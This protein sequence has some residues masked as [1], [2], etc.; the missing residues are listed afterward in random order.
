MRKTSRGFNEIKWTFS[1]EKFSRKQEA[2]RI[3]WDTPL[4]T[5]AV[6]LGA[7][8]RSGRGKSSIVYAIGCGCE[9]PLINT[10]FQVELPIGLANI[11]EL[12][13]TPE[14]FAQQSPFELS[15]EPTRV[16]ACIRFSSE[17]YL[18]TCLS[19]F[20]QSLP[21]CRDLPTLDPKYVCAH[22]AQYAPKSTLK[23]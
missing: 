5:N 12:V 4:I 23:S 8:N 7:S 11:Q 17:P 22:S 20:E 14:K 18:G 9:S 10:L 2:E 15:P 1:S 21:I 19:R 13:D 6:A 16:A 3:R